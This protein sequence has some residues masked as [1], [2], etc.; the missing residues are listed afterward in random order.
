MGMPIRLMDEFPDDF[1]NEALREIPFP[2]AD[3]PMSF[4]NRTKL[5]A[6]LADQA[7]ERQRAVE[8]HRNHPGD[9]VSANFQ[10]QTAL[11][12]MIRALQVA[13]LEV[14]SDVSHNT[15]TLRLIE[16]NQQVLIA[17]IKKLNRQIEELKRGK[18]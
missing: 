18:A 14:E 8:G 6:D 16:S 13:I 17:Q 7:G 5:A 9:L 15:N 1:W 12:W 2:L 11:D 4:A 3:V 10:P